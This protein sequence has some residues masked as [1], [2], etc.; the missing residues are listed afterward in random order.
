M[1]P[2]LADKHSLQ[3]LEV[4]LF[5]HNFMKFE[6][7]LCTYKNADHNV[8]QDLFMAKKILDKAGIPFEIEYLGRSEEEFR[9]LIGAYAKSN[10]VDLISIMNF[11]GDNIFNFGTKSFVEGLIR[12]EQ[13]I[14]ILTVQ[15]QR[16]EEYSGFHSAG[17]Y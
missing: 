14:P 11:T 9:R 15:N 16:L 10:N 4:L 13:Q 5:L 6:L 17:G 8:N 2:I 7:T 3:N 1:A 12:N